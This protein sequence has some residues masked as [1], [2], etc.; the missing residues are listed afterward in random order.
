[1][2]YCKKNRIYLTKCRKLTQ[3]KNNENILLQ[4]ANEKFTKT[5]DP[6]PAPSYIPLKSYHTQDEFVFFPKANTQSSAQGRTMHRGATV[7]MPNS[8]WKLNAFS[9]AGSLLLD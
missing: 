1:M 6:T 7:G 5:A 8:V 3:L 4:Q 9:P 2:T